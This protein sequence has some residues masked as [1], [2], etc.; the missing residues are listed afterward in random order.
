MYVIVTDMFGDRMYLAW[1]PLIYDYGYFWT[2]KETFNKC[3]Y[4]KGWNTREHMF[5]FSSHDQAMDALLNCDIHRSWK[6]HIVEI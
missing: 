5:A 4:D 1:Q 3:L 6:A 2:D